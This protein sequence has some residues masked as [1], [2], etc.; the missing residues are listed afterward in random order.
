[1]RFGKNLLGMRVCADQA[2]RQEQYFCPTCNEPLVLRKGQILRPHFAHHPTRQCRDDWTYDET[3]WQQ[4]WQSQFPADNQEVIVTQG[5]QMHRADVIMGNTVLLFQQSPI[6]AK[7]FAEKTKYFLQ[8][9]KDVFWIFD[10][11]KDYATKSLKP[12]PRNQNNLF[13]DTP[14]ACLK[15]FDL[16]ANKHVHIFLSISDKRVLKVEWV[17]PDSGFKRLI[18]D[19]SF[20]PDFLTEEGC[21]EAKLNQYGRF[22]AFKQKNAPWH[23]KASS[24]AGAP[25]KRWHLCDKSGTWHLDKCKTCPYNLINEYRSGN[26]KTNIRGGLFFYCRYP[27]VVNPVVAEKDGEQVADV[28][29]IWLK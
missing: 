18:V 20:Y 8:D 10:V 16:S 3:A 14:P 11:E 9:N 27:Q 17:A 7:F 29:S 28:R 13:W 15:K 1:M 5:R 21:A 22:D 19:S 12:N 25:D 4:V 23:K 26:T 24:T 6:A 2:V